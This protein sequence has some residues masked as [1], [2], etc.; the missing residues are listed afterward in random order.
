MA[1]ITGGGLP[2]NVCRALPDDLDAVIDCTTW[3]PQPI[4]PFLQRHGNVQ[5][6]EMFKV[7]NMGIGY[8]LVV[9]PKFAD[10]IEERLGKY[11]ETVHRIG[12]IVKAPKGAKEGSV[13][14]ENLPG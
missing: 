1:H 5:T 11:G 8:V 2:G 4:F 3:T 6:A 12:E 14:L 7:F 9:R 13:R 10:A